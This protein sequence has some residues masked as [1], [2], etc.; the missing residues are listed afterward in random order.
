M[1]WSSFWKIRHGFPSIIAPEIKG[2]DLGREVETRRARSSEYSRYY[3]SAV[4]SLVTLVYKSISAVFGTIS[5][6]TIGHFSS[7]G[8]HF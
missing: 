3:Q 5:N 6:P 8:I 2:S 7:N 1:T 4:L